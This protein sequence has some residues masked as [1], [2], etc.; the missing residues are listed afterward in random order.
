MNGRVDSVELH[1]HAAVVIRNVAQRILADPM[2]V[3][4]RSEAARWNRI[5]ELAPADHTD[6]M[7]GKPARG[8][9]WYPT[10]ASSRRSSSVRPAPVPG[11]GVRLQHAARTAGALQYF[12]EG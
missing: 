3:T 8:R 9:R 6:V 1:P 7:Y 5:G 4:P 12:G 10:I 11:P 2:N